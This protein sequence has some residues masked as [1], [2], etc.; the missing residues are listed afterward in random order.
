M[1]LSKQTIYIQILI[2]QLVI[3]VA[4]QHPR[5]RIGGGYKISA[6]VCTQ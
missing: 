1:A 2:N 3:N 4:Y 6:V 5:L